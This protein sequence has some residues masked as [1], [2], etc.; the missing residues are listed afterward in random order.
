[1]NSNFIV[2]IIIIVV[3]FFIA[4]ATIRFKDYSYYTYTMLVP[5]EGSGGEIIDMQYE[6]LYLGHIL[7]HTKTLLFYLFNLIYTF[8]I[9]IFIYHNFFESIYS[10]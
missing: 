8:Y 9:I 2:Y 3:S 1:M 7:L 6:N 4:F 10:N 5:I